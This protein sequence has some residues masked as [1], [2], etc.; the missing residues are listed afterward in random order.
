MGK[1]SLKKNRF[2]PVEYDIRPGGSGCGDD[3]SGQRLRNPAPRHDRIQ[4]GG[5]RGAFCLWRMAGSRPNA[6]A[7]ARH[8]S[9]F[10]RACRSVPCRSKGL[11][12]SRQ[13]RCKLVRCRCQPVGRQ[14]SNIDRQRVLYSASHH[15]HPGSMCYRRQRTRCQSDDSKTRV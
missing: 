10:H 15:Q 6:K 2:R 7:H 1:A 4:P 13:R 3:P 12:N 8:K 5:I 11:E 9:L 14:G